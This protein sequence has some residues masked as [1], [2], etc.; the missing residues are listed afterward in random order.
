MNEPS[1]VRV[2]IDHSVGADDELVPEM[3]SSPRSTGALVG[4]LGLVGLVVLALL[5]F[6]PSDD[7]ESVADAEPGATTTP[8]A[9]ADAEITGTTDAAAPVGSVPLEQSLFSPIFSFNSVVRENGPE[10]GTFLAL[11]SEVDNR[12]PRIFRSDQGVSWQPVMAS[13]PDFGFEGGA[14]WVEYSHLIQDGEELAMLRMSS[15]LPRIR[16][17]LSPVVTVHRLLSSDGATWRIDESFAPVEL[18]GDATPVFHDTNS[19]GVAEELA[20]NPVEGSGCENTFVA[21]SVG[22]DV[23][24][25]RRGGPEVA[26]I[27]G[28]TATGHTSVDGG[29]VAALT[30]GGLAIPESCAADDQTLDQLPTPTLEILSPDGSAV[31]IEIPAAVQTSMRVD[32]V[33]TV[34][35][36]LSDDRLVTLA[37]NVVWGLDLDGQAWSLRADRS[38]DAAADFGFRLKP[39]GWLV[40][41]DTGGLTFTDLNTG[42]V[43]VRDGPRLPFR[44]ILYLDDEFLLIALNRGV[45]VAINVNIARG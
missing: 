19:F 3:P 34:D 24:V 30:L 8:S 15:S 20:L 42:E 35:F 22:R 28:S 36:L 13:M 14:V 23:L 37:G 10:T 43:I 33:S 29:L 18:L 11:S 31:S 41:V 4:V 6:G 16:R 44:N 26:T 1:P 25:Q 27:S 40:G 2:E 32:G 38:G 7:R 12:D 5:I 17:S 45:S 39:D 9:L 21:E